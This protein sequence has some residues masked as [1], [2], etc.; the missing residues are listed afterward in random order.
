MTTVTIN[1]GSI[2]AIYT[3]PISLN[4]HRRSFSHVHLALNRLNASIAASHDTAETYAVCLSCL[5]FR[6]GEVY[7]SQVE[8]KS[9]TNARNAHRAVCNYSYIENGK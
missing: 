7:Q 1:S 9:N 5:S 4:Y 8:I 2:M 3:S 6:N